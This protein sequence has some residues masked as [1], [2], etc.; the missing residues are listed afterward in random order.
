[1]NNKKYLYKPANDISVTEES[2]ATAFYLNQKER[3]NKI[4]TTEDSSV[5]EM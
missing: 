3:I 1:M 4:S 5:V 2:S